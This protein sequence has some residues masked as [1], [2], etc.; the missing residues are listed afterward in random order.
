MPK[1]NQ[2]NELAR[3][4]LGRRRTPATPP[5]P[6]TAPAAPPPAAATTAAAPVAEAPTLPWTGS[7]ARE[8]V[9]RFYPRIIELPDTQGYLALRFYLSEC[10]RTLMTTRRLPLPE[11][12]CL[13]GPLFAAGDIPT[14][15]ACG[16]GE[17]RQPVQRNFRYVLPPIFYAGHAEME[18]ILQQTHQEVARLLENHRLPALPREAPVAEE[19]VEL[20]PPAPPDWLDAPLDALEGPPPGLEEQQ[21][22]P[23][24]E[25]APENKPPIE[26]W[27]GVIVQWL[28]KGGKSD[29]EGWSDSP[30]LRIQDEA[31]GGEI[32]PIRGKDLLRAMKESHAQTGDRVLVRHVEN[33]PVEVFQKGD[34]KRGAYKKVFYIKVLE[35]RRPG[36]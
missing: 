9:E 7:A 8:Q 21:A 16:Q 2:L 31:K 17:Q 6:A 20:L 13:A 33:T 15:H 24:A 22:A 5:A 25:E 27:K 10:R 14:T 12:A 18:A 11:L 30:V 35:Q 32:T 3:Q 36:R 1:L 34:R 26:E 28:P 19:A 29:R 4:F 23:V